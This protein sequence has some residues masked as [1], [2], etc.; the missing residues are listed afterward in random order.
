MENALYN[1]SQVLGITIIHSLWQGLV[2][3]FMLR[4]AL[5]FGDNLPS[6]K[7]YLLGVTSLLA[8]T[9]WFIFTL[10]NEIELYNWL[11]RVPEK[12]SA[13]PLMLELPGGI[14]RFDDETIRYYY[15]IEE[16]LPYITIIYIAGLLFNSARLIMGRRRI[17]TIRQTMSIDVQ[18][19]LQVNK[20]TGMLNIDQKVKIG[21]S[22]L[23]DVP[24]MVGYFKPV[25]LLPFILSTYLGAEEIEAV[26]LHEL[27]HIKRNDYLVNLLQQVVATLLFFNPCALLINKFINEE[28]ENCCDDLVVQAT[29][30]PIIYAKALLKLEQT[31]ENNFRMAMSATG[32]K[33]QLL[34]R[35]ER[36]MK[37]KKTIPSIRPA[38]LAMLIITAGIGL[39]ALLNPKIAKGKISI[40]AINPVIVN[41][42]ADT[43]HKTKVV[44]KSATAN[45]YKK[46]KAVVKADKEDKKVYA[47]NYNKNRNFNF[48]FNFNG[49]NNDPELQKLSDEINKYGDAINKYYESPEYKKNADDLEA[50]GKELQAFFDKPELKKLQ[51]EENRLSDDLNKKWSDNSE[52]NKVTEQME[53]LGKKME[54]YYNSTEFKEMAARL[55]KKYGIKH[56]DYYEDRDENHLKF[57]E[58]LKANI[59]A[60]ITRA[61]EEIKTLGEQMRNRYKSPEYIAQRDE[62]RKMGDSLRNA[63]HNPQIKEKQDEMR[64]LSQR[65]REFNHNPDI[66]KEKQLLKEASAKLR[67]Y[68]HSPEF[69]KR[70][71]I[72]E[73]SD[74]RP[75]RPEAPEK[76]EKPEAPEK[77]DTTKQ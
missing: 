16:Y 46:P 77:P 74:E 13:M 62:M 2:I 63:Y 35:I 15:S 17:N 28:R 54:T 75:E 44:K 39:I 38:L 23:V 34:N 30:S 41:L 11:A 72:L 22:K 33:Y 52:T 56:D 76:P 57:R 1:I 32:K 3:Y 48:D 42:L 47:Y 4:L 50:K 37:T 7:K 55:E 51:E 66:E 12:L 40:K 71:S 31:R 5:I 27:A 10:I 53:A 70:L 14:S 45:I 25:I 19:Q 65:M 26:L 73:K 58:E 49:N 36:I 61:S 29:P 68:I 59:P 8:M 67:A 43:A 20:F 69:I 18:L 6:P 64:K 21:L 9:C 60:E 24:C